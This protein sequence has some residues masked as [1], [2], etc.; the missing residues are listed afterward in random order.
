[1][2]KVTIQNKISRSDIFNDMRF[3]RMCINSALQG[4]DIT[5]N[6]ENIIYTFL[7]SESNNDLSPAE[8]YTSSSISKALYSVINKFLTDE[9]IDYRFNYLKNDFAKFNKL[10]LSEKLFK[11]SYKLFTK[12]E[13][14]TIIQQ[15]LRLQIL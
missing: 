4:I 1:M 2:P 9:L 7:T 11:H 6:M 10:S 12:K 14:D 15:F 3:K 13:L 8:T 5:D